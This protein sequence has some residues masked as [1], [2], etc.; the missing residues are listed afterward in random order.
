MP[1]QRKNRPK[2]AVPKL[3]EELP[4]YYTASPE[5]YMTLVEIAEA[6]GR[7]RVAVEGW[8]GRA[9]H[10][11][12]AWAQHE[13]TVWVQQGSSRSRAYRVDP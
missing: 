7:T 5:G 4:C 2:F 12:E 3:S 10:K 6:T 13:N 9:R 11:G 8:A 1:T